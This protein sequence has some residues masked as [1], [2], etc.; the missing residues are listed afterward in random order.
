VFDPEGNGMKKPVE[1][2]LLTLLF[3]GVSF[4]QTATTRTEKK[5]GV[6]SQGGIAEAIIAREEGFWDAWKNR[7]ADFFKANLAAESIIVA[8]TGRRTKAEILE[9][10]AKSDC[11]VEDY[12]LADFKTLALGKKTTLLTYYV[13]YRITCGGKEQAQRVY[14]SSIYV[15]PSGPLLRVFHQETAASK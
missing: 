1:L 6:R 13:Q 5:D 15:D 4:G 3:I 2:A 9:E 7:R 14:A 12:S 10:V 11:V 8:G